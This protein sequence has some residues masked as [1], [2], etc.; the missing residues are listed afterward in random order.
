MA[1]MRNAARPRI[2]PGNPA[3]THHSVLRP[4]T[5]IEGGVHHVPITTPMQATADPAAIPVQPEGIRSRYD[6]HGPRPRAAKFWVLPV[7][8]VAAG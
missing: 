1:A 6:R 8:G 4:P 3:V 7:A 5:I 2:V